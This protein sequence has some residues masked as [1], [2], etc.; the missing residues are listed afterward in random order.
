[1]WGNIAKQRTPARQGGTVG[2]GG[3]VRQ[4]GADAGEYRVRGVP[5][6]LDFG[7]GLGASEPV[8]LPARPRGVG[9]SQLAIGGERGLQRDQRPAGAD[10]LGEGVVEPARLVLQQAHGN[11]DASGPKPGNSLP[12]D[13]RIGIDHGHDNAPHAG[14]DQRIGARPGAAMVTA[15]FQRDVRSGTASPRA[16]LLEGNDLG[17][18]ELVVE[19][20]TLA[21]DLAVAHQHAAD[22]GIGRSQPDG[23]LR[24][25]ERAP[26]LGL[27]TRMNRHKE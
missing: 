10:E 22:L 12:A 27:V 9:R 11:F 18:V 25:I 2:E 14:G 13:A 21:D 23:R 7:T 17:V 19:M 15:W 26:H 3:I 20:R 8:R 16:C 24:Q 1:M 4:H 6:A 5:H